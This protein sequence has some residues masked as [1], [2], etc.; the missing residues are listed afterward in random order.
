MGPKLSSNIES[1]LFDLRQL[2]GDL[3]IARTE[4][5]HQHQTILDEATVDGPLKFFSAAV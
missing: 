1:S 2:L 3:I 4:V 5:V